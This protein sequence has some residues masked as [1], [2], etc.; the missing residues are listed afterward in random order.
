MRSS[1]GRFWTRTASCLTVPFPSMSDPLRTALTAVTSCAARMQPVQELLRAHAAGDLPVTIQGLQG[2]F[3]A[4]VTALLSDAPGAVHDGAI[5]VVTPT[6]QEADLVAADLRLFTGREVIELPWWGTLPY[7]RQA[8]LPAVFGRRADA[9]VRLA[10]GDGCLA[11]APLR[12]LL[13]PTPER[14]HLLAHTIGFRTGQEVDPGK[15]AETLAALG[16][17]R[18][19]RVSVH[20]EFSVKAR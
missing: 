14:S 12:A 1:C 15:T 6:E 13:T 18:V 8:P 5:L 3:L 7:A 4:V 2:S 16:Y 11:V 17:L 9:L 20:G 10:S 19:P